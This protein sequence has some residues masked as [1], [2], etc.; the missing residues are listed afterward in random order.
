MTKTSELYAEVILFNVS[1]V[2][3]VGCCTMPWDRY[4]RPGTGGVT[5]YTLGCQSKLLCDS[6]TTAGIGKRAAPTRMKCCN[7]NLCNNE[8]LGHPTG[9]VTE[10][11][12][13]VCDD[14]QGVD[15][16][17]LRAVMDI[18]GNPVTAKTYCAKTCAQQQQ[19]QY[20]PQQKT[21]LGGVRATTTWDTM[22][23]TAGQNVASTSTTQPPRT[24]RTPISSNLGFQLPSIPNFSNLNTTPSLAGRQPDGTFN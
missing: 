11:P 12:I 1:T 21:F 17:A 6:I 22:G 16:T 8:L 10:P 14:K 24:A 2:T 13:T 9:N 15:C 7:T 4:L 19:H 20:Q 3:G 18:C 5:R 23:P